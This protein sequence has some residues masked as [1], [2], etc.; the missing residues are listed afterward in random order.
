[1]D[2]RNIKMT[3]EEVLQKLKE[4]HKRYPHIFISPKEYKNL[5]KEYERNVVKSLINYY[6]TTKPSYK[7]PLVFTR[8]VKKILLSH[9]SELIPESF[10]KKKMGCWYQ[11]YFEG[12]SFKIHYKK[13]IFETNFKNFNIKTSKNPHHD[14]RM[15]FN[16]YLRYYKLKEGDVVV[17]AG[18]SYGTLALYASKIVGDSGKVIAFEPSPENY[19]ILKKNVELNDLNNVILLKK[20]VWSKNTFLEFNDDARGSSLFFDNKDIN[21]I[22]KIPV[23]R[24][25]DELKKLGINKVNFVKMDIESAEIGALQGFKNNLQN[26]DVNLAI[27]SYHRINGKPSYLLLENFF[28]KIGYKA[29]TLYSMYLTTYAYKKK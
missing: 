17:D 16:E 22:I 5:K 4:L 7:K 29:K 21:K 19:E 11:N 28:R 12:N 18:A 8:I 1:M 6:N 2:K 13:G 23:V 20:A 14:F 26:N 24:L 9:L 10:L 27:A 3:Y 25:D 15:I